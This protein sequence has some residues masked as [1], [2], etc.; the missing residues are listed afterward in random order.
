MC[1]TS[2][3]SYFGLFKFLGLIVFSEKFKNM[4]NFIFIY[5]VSDNKNDTD[6]GES[7]NEW[8]NE[9]ERD[10]A[11]PVFWDGMERVKN[12]TRHRARLG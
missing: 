12:R 3:T 8:M 10:M 9:S 7:E 6:S 2:V 11:G 1:W 5:N 4:C